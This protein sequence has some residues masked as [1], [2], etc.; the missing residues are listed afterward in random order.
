MPP[1]ARVEAMR[2]VLARF[3]YTDKDH[4]VVGE[5]DPRVVGE[6]ATLLEEG[7]DDDLREGW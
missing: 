7:E 2:S 6:A 5:P 3:D 1:L 4:E